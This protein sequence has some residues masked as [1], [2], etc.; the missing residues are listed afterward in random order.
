MCRSPDEPKEWPTDDNDY[1]PKSWLLKKG[2]SWQN[3]EDGPTE[4]FKGS[5]QTD[6]S[7]RAGC[8]MGMF[9]DEQSLS[10]RKYIASLKSCPVF[11]AW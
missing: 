2:Q 4:K 3:V 5:L 9:I 11:C 7:H 1:D 10:V 8:L 6:L